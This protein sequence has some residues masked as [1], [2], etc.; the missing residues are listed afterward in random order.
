MHQNT[1][2]KLI[3]WAE[4]SDAVE[5]LVL[6]SSRVNGSAAP[7]DQFSDYDVAVYVDSLDQYQNDDW[8]KFFGKVLVRWPQKPQSTFN[9]NWLTRL[10]IFE[11]RLRIDFQITTNH[12]VYPVGYDLGYQVLVDKIGFTKKFPKATNTEHFIKKPSEIEFLTLVNDFFWD[13]TYVPKYL[14]RNDLFYAKFMFDSMIRF[15]Y[16]EKVIEWYIGSE[17]SWSVGTNVHGRY[18]P[19]YIDQQTWEEIE[20]TFAGSDV[21]ENWAAF[22]K[23]VELFTR[24]A[25][26]AAE[27]LG[28][29]Y[30]L[31]QEKRVLAYYQQSKNIVKN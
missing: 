4:R 10:V 24:F 21:E 6:T 3:E 7:V 2:K 29:E 20:K 26:Q 5:A 16:F 19:R 31:E 28:Y 25:K 22:F 14:W 23:M 30:P 11:D 9:V 13:A 1:V 8:L 18:F 17:N 27:H 12:N 15:E